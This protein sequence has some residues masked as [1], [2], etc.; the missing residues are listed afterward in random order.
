[1]IRLIFFLILTSYL[2]AE[3]TLTWAHT[4]SDLPVDSKAHFGE[5][6]NGLRYIIYPNQEPPGRVSIRLHIDAGSLLEEDDQRGIAHFLEHMLFDGSKNFSSDELI[7]EMQRLGIAFGAHAN[8]YT[9]FDETVYMLD[10]PNLEEDTLNL[11]F[12]VMRDFCDG[13][14]LKTDAIES[15]RGVILSEKN[16]RDSVDYRLMQQQ[17]RFLIPDHKAAYRFPIGIEETINT[18]PPERI[19]QFYKDYYDPRLSTF[20]VVGDIEVEA[21]EEWC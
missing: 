4:E 14:L 1:M 15:E 21:M 7:P 2:S 8:A 19:R 17:F 5:L 3:S 13:A 6:E 11:G 9:S 16:S 10:L 12:T 20:V 18:T